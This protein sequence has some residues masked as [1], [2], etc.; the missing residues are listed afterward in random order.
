MARSRFAQFTAGSGSSR[1]HGMPC[2]G[3]KLSARLAI[4]NS[5]KIPYRT[6]IPKEV[7]RRFLPG[8]KVRS[9]PRI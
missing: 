6:D 2:R 7:T 9:P 5:L 1:S 3:L 4:T 8:L